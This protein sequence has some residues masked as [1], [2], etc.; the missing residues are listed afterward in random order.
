M[1][2]SRVDRER[3]IKARS[4]SSSEISAQS[5]ITSKW[6]IQPLEE[7]EVGGIEWLGGIEAGHR[8]DDNVRMADENTLVIHL[9]WSGVIVELGVCEETGLQ[10]LE[11]EFESESLV[12]CNFAKVEWEHEFGGWDLVLGDDATLRNNVA[13]AGTDLLAVSQR[14]AGQCV[15][16]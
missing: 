16:F 15:S 5:R 9:S 7:R 14:N 3:T 12:G 11:L 6:R 2:G 1:V 13:R 8:L 10:V 4:Q